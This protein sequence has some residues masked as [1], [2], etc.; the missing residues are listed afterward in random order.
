MENS[1]IV[2]SGA[3]IAESALQNF[4]NQVF[5]CRHRRKSFPFTPRGEEQCYA[6]CLDCGQRLGS[7]L[8]V[9][10][11][12]SKSGSS[13]GPTPAPARRPETVANEV[14]VPDMGLRNWKYDLLWVGL[15]LVGLSG[16]LNLTG[17]LQ[18]GRVA[19]TPAPPL[20]QAACM[21]APAVETKQNIPDKNSI[22]MP[23]KTVA[24]RGWIAPSRA[25]NLAESPQTWRLQ[26]KSPFVVLGL[27]APAVLD[28]SRDPG[29]LHDL[30]QTGSLFTVANGTAIQVLEVQSRVMKVHILEGSMTG[31]EGWAQ[32]S[33]IA[34]RR[35]PPEPRRD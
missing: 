20:P 22:E 2:G 10:E 17:R 21:Q 11:Q 9:M 31:R 12:P 26:G 14:L 8:Q 18:H 34:P 24:A 3:N 35:R 23:A 27:E 33:Q 25:A 16:G 29:R 6:V 28:L 1:A 15:F 19:A 30:I 5:R 4:L 13:A 32:A 7:D